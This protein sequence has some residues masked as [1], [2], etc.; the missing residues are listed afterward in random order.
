MLQKRIFHKK[1]NTS[2]IDGSNEYYAN[3]HV[4]VIGDIVV[5]IGAI[6]IANHF[7]LKIFCLAQM[8]WT[9]LILFINILEFLSSLSNYTKHKQQ[10]VNLLLSLQ[11]PMIAECCS[12]LLNPSDIFYA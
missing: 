10:S 3:P 7:N 6:E 8:R 1:S 9:L 2:Q 11:L 4:I 12:L 5:F